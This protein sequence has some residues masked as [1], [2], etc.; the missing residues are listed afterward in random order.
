MIYLYL[1]IHNKTGLKYLGKTTKKD[2]HSYPGSGKRW[3]RHLR[4]HGFDYTTSIL[5]ATECDKELKETGIFFS[6]LFN[7]VESPEWANLMEE[8]GDGVDSITASKENKRRVKEGIHHWQ[9]DGSFQRSVQN[10]KINEGTHHFL[11]GKLQRRLSKEKVDNGT[12]NFFFIDRTHVAVNNAKMVEE[13][14]HHFLGPDFNKRMIKE[15]K[16]TSQNPKA[17]EKIRD[18]TN[19]RIEDGSHAWVKNVV[20]VNEDGST[21]TV[22]IDEYRNNKT[23]HKNISSNEGRKRLGLPPRGPTW[24]S[25]KKLEK[26]IKCPHCNRLGASMGNMKRHHFDNCKLLISG[27]REL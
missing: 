18:K 13:G 7:I 3:L 12:H 20:C 17:I 24:N 5:L 6:N 22:K 9:G 23:I 10:K 11:G 15:G 21:Y 26:K 16:H 4:K 8:K 14:T 25:G 27:N 2:Y 19:S 1:K